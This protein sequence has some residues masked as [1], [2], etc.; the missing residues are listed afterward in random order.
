MPAKDSHKTVLIVDDE[1]LFLAS[2][3]EGLKGFGDEFKVVT[4]ENGKLALEEL[5][6]REISLVVTDLKMPVMDGFQ[7]LGRML[8]EFPDLPIIVMTAHCTPEIEAKIREL[9]AFELLEKPVDLSLLAAKIRDGI[10]QGSDG[11]VK[12]IMLFSFL[13]LIEIEQKSC[14]LKVK[15]GG[16]KGSLFFSKGVLIDAVC[17]EKNGIDAAHEI[18]CWEDTEIEILNTTKKIRRRIDKPLQNI[19]MDAAKQKD[20]AFFNAGSDTD[21]DS[22]A[23]DAV[24]IP[25]ADHVRP[26]SA[27]ANGSS[28][29]DPNSAAST[30]AADGAVRISKTL[31]E[32]NNIMANN[33]EQSLGE[34]MNI[35]GAMACALV[36]TGSGMALGTA[37]GGVN[38]EVAA[39]GNTEVVKSK[40]KVMGSLGLK[41]KIEDILITLGS[42]YHLIRPLTEHTG[43]FF[44]LVLNREKSNLA[45]ARTKLTGIEGSVQL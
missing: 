30:A 36:D 2:L 20:E 15:S 43:L 42:Q 40:Q 33:I 39:A 28:P 25:Q 17:G 34:L 18:V 7:L 10:Q 45:L 29:A 31:Q 11:H 3:V 38:L 24:S 14:A 12:G 27:A 5:K 37:G 8:N 41:D 6:K 16:Q 13:Q 19:L 32:Q 9:D 26:T 35:D 21:F 1:K 44:Y 22:A 4:A 23:E